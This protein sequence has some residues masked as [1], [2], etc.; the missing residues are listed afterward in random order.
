MG[1]DLSPAVYDF[2]GLGL[3]EALLGEGALLGFEA[4]RQHLPEV[5]H[6]LGLGLLL[7]LVLKRR[8]SQEFPTK[9]ELERFKSSQKM[10]SFEHQVCLEFIIKI[11]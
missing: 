2:S 8:T 4:V 7:L 10:F 3:V 11:F 9:K 1:G 5:V 6:D